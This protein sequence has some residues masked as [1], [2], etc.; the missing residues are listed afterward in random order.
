MDR[1][2]HIWIVKLIDRQ[3]KTKLLL[4]VQIL[5]KKNKVIQTFIKKAIT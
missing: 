4:T 2:K 1:Q 3:F 5:M